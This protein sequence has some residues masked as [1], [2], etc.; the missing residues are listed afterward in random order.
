MNIYTKKN[1]SK[2][3]TKN[4]NILQRVIDVVKLIGKRSLRYRGHRNEGTDSLNDSTLNHSNFLDISLLLKKCDVVL[5]E[6]IDLITKNASANHKRE[7]GKEV[8]DL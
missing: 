4:R 8:E 1:D 5:S 2:K 7:K 3:V 6:H